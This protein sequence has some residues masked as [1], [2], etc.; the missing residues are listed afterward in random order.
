MQK[1]EIEI[2]D[3]KKIIPYVRN[4]AKH[5]IEVIIRRWHQYC[6]KN[7]LPT[8]FKHLNGDLKLEQIVN[9]V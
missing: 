2:W 1:D 9:E 8:D 6:V 7:N 4:P 5:P 3:I